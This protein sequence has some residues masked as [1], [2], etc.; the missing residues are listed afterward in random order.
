LQRPGIQ[1]LNPFVNR[2]NPQLLSTGN[3]LLGPVTSHLYEL[4]YSR[5]AKGTLSMRGT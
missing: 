4:V 3:P 2:A 5:A 1:Q